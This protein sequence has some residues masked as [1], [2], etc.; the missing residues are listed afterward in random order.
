MDRKKCVASSLGILYPLESSAP[1]A[2]GLFRCGI[3]REEGE[4][5]SGSH[6][7]MQLL[8]LSAVGH[9]CLPLTQLTEGDGLM[10]TPPFRHV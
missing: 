1:D 3:C 5:G 10:Q 9:A 6:L 8:L 2:Q 4:N 7:L